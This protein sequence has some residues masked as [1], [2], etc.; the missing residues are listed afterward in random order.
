[1]KFSVLCLKKKVAECDRCG[2]GTGEGD[3]DGQGVMIRRRRRCVVSDTGGEHV[4]F[5]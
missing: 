1:M 5:F 3:S 2:G 4:V